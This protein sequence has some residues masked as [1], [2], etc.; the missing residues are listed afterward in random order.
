MLAAHGVKLSTRDRRPP[1]FL[2]DAGNSFGVTGIEIINRLLR[3]F[4]DVTQGMNAD[5]ELVRGMSCTP[6]IFSVDVNE[7]TEPPRLAA[8]DGDHQRQSERPG[9]SEGFR[10]PTHAK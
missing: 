5:F 7:R 3:R 8:N 2:A 6:A 10:C 4:G 9:A 1:A